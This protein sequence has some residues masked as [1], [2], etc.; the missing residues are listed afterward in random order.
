MKFTIPRNDLADML[1]KG[2]TSN[3][4]VT[5]VP[6]LKHA[7]LIAKDNQLRVSTTNLDL[8]AETIGAVSIEVEGETTVD[9]EK[10]KSTVDRLPRGADISVWLDGG[11]LFVKSGRS[12]V[13]LPTLPVSD[14][15]SLDSRFGSDA[16]R[17]NVSGAELDRLLG[18]TTP[19]G[20]LETVRAALQG[21]FVHVREWEGVRALAAAASNGHTFLITTIEAEVE[22]VEHLP[23]NGGGDHGVLLP[24]KTAE[25]ALALFRGESSVR[26]SAF[27]TIAGSSPRRAA[28]SSGSTGLI[29][30]RES[31]CSKPSRRRNTVTRSKPARP[32][33]AL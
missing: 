23:A 2:G 30:A 24:I 21:V 28:I 9:A 12:R 14:W 1:A 20:A 25:K 29:V 13:R 6:I 33:P 18:R 32:I 19:V 8:Q 31:P 26:V 27:R 4:K 11:D 22:G 16:A 15:P 3:E 5:T 10:L 17:F 7:R